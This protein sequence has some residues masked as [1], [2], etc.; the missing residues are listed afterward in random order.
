MRPQL[1]QSLQSNQYNASETIRGD[2]LYSFPGSYRREGLLSL[3]RDG[4]LI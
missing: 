2:I 3:G 1:I 4:A